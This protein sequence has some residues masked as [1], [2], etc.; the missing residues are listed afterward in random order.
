MIT[1]SG[2]VQEET[3]ALGVPCFTVRENTERPITVSEG[4]NRLVPNPEEL[5][6]A[7]VSASRPKSPPRP[8]GWDGHASERIVRA[9][10]RRETASAEA[11]LATAPTA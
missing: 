5:E 6:Q 3:T 2:G 9:F 8:D 7:V 4:T 10:E 1:D 11:R